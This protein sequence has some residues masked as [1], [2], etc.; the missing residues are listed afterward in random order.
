MIVATG[1]AAAQAVTMAFAPVITRIYGPEAFGILGV[2]MAMV[3]IIAPLAALTYPTAIVLPKGDS[4]AK[5]IIRISLYVSICI[6][7]ITALILLFFNR[8]LVYLLKIEDI[9]PFL[10]LIPLVIL[11]SAFLQ[12]AQQWLI[13]TKKFRVTAKA[14]FL[15]S[16]I[17]NI[18]KVGFGWFYPVATVLVILATLGS[19]IHALMLILGIRRLNYTQIRGSF[20]FTKLKVLALKYRDFPIFRAP[21]VFTYAISQS[22]PILLLSSFFGPA[23]AGLYSISRTVLVMPITLIGKSIGDVLY[24]KLTETFNDGK[25]ITK[26]IV[27]ATL[28]LSA[29]G[30]I[31]FGVVIAF[32]PW[33]FSFV[34]G[35]EWLL[36]G[37]YARWLAFWLFFMFINRPSVIAIPILGLQGKFLVYEVFSI[38]LK[39]IAILFGFFFFDNDILAVALYSI[40]GVIAY[41]FLIFWV[42][43]KSK[44]FVKGHRSL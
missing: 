3:G 29:L 38:L 15:N 8:Q 21:Q 6:A 7:T 26:M 30:I 20:G 25:G 27:K 4:D 43:K 12:V 9:A 37:E 1:T 10:Y 39:V 34:F 36:A 18:A 33:L 14:A 28:G 41:L 40:A 32:G 42:I 44:S 23:S 31:P 19:A 17:L 2:F 11:F 22:L 24:P 13:R 5:G 16:L 35:S